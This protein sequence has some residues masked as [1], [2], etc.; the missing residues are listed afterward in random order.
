MIIQCSAKCGGGWRRRSVKCDNVSKL[1]TCRNEAKPTEFE[2]CNTH[3]CLT[4]KWNTDNW[5][6]VIFKNFICTTSLNLVF[7]NLRKRHTDS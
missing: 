4:A 3:A 7:C 1:K 6:Q 5:S 2:K